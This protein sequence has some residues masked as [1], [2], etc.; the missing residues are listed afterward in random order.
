MHASFSQ[1]Y[2]GTDAETIF[3]FASEIRIDPNLKTPAYVAFKDGSI[4]PGSSDFNILRALAHL[5]MEDDFKLIKTEEDEMGVIHKRLQQFYQGIKVEHGIYI[6]HEQ[7][8]KLISANGC[9]FSGIELDIKPVVNEEVSLLAALNHIKA[10]KYIW[11]DSRE[12][13]MLRSEKHDNQ[14]TWYPKGELV[15][16]PRELMDKRSATRLCWKFDIYSTEPLNRY[17]IYVDAIT[18]NIIYKENR[19]C[20]IPAKHYP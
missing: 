15:I 9:Y 7:Q 1:V 6:F 2:Y 4:M 8:E 5:R 14:A 20:T 11:E 19:I 18:G 3:P 16:F 17:Y 10:K 13:A 12:E